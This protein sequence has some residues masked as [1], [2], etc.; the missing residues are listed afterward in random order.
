LKINHIKF[1]KILSPNAPRIL[2]TCPKAGKLIEEMTGVDKATP[3]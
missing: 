2:S 1:K 3:T